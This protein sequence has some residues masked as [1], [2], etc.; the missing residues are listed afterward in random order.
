MGPCLVAR[1]QK[2]MS[3]AGN[4]VERQGLGVLTSC[5]LL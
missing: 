4:L 5:Q 3:S 2:I 1:R